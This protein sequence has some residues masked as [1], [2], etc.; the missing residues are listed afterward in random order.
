MIKPAAPINRVYVSSRFALHVD[1]QSALTP[2]F[3]K[4]VDGGGITAD[5]IT[6]QTGK[7]T[8]LWRYSG[9][10]KYEDFTIQVGM[11]MSRGFYSWIEAFF[12]RKYDRRNGAI[13]SANFNYQE[14]SRRVFENAM[15]SEVSFPAL[16]GADK[17]PGYLTVKLSPE[18]VTYQPGDNHIL[19]ETF[20]NRQKMWKPANF[21]VSI[22]SMPCKRISKVEG[23]AVKQQILENKTGASLETIKV[24]GRIEWPNIS[25]MVPEVDIG[26]W[27]AWFEAEVVKGQFKSPGKQG[28]LS[29]KSPDLVTEYLHIDLHNIGISGCK[30][31]KGE[32]GTDA[33]RKWKIDLHVDKLT[34]TYKG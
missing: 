20:Q 5:V 27:A 19:K 1:G 26:P 12:A 13:I 25:L 6:V 3:V 22:G 14:Q 15:I 9:K 17:N 31:E 28:W 4:S 8:D 30:P 10:P 16:D 24:P 33:I 29:L 7:T 32:A 34:C 23:F 21:A 2:G 18:K 11:G